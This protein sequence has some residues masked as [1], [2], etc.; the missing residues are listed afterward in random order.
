MFIAAAGGQLGDADGAKSGRDLLKFRPELPAWMRQ[1][2]AKIW[3]PEYGE[4]FLE[5]L[6]KAGMEIRRC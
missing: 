3:N 2:V 6:R 4:R 1:Q 5:G